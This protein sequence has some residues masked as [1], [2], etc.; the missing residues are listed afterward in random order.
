[1]ADLKN[2]AQMGV[3]EV[4]EDLAYNVAYGEVYNKLNSVIPLD[5]GYLKDALQSGAAVMFSG[6]L[7]YYMQKQDFVIQKIFDH[8]NNALFV[9]LSGAGGFLNKLTK[10]KGRKLTNYVNTILGAEKDK[11][12]K[13]R[14]VIEYGNML[15]Q[16]QIVSANYNNSGSQLV[17]MQNLKDVQNSQKLEYAKAKLDSTHK[18]LLLKLF[19]SRFTAD[20]IDMIKKMTGKSNVDI[21][22]LNKI[23]NFMYV[24][25]DS[26]NI[27]GLTEQ[28]MT[29]LNG[30]GYLNN[31]Q[32]KG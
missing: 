6:A 20:D 15:H 1:M 12:E 14:M 19:T 30:L 31:K 27:T 22:N 8:I 17:Q 21:D 23:A 24:T 9:L 5:D 10:F 18:N 2:I 25:D 32:S 13:S 4:F 7:M 26:G 16:G 3:N 28:F 11:N 29:M